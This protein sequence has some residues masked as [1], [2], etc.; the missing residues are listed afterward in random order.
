MCSGEAG[1]LGTLGWIR[2]WKCRDCGA[3]FGKKIRR[4]PRKEKATK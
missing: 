3:E 4:R 2:Y 1:I